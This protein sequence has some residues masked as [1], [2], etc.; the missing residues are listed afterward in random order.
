MSSGQFITSYASF[1][2]TRFVLL[3]TV[4][5]DLYFC[6]FRYKT[7]KNPSK[8]DGLVHQKGE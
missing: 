7:Q 3:F 2:I 6:G 5:N 1:L 4:R 8:E